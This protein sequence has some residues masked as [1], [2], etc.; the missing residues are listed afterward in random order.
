M[1]NNIIFN[2]LQQK[3]LVSGCQRHLSNNHAASVALKV[4]AKQWGK[5]SVVYAWYIV[6]RKYT[7]M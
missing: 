6:V 7:A 5:E 3:L 2:S 1:N 4:A